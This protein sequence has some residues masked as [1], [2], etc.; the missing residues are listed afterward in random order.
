MGDGRQTVVQNVERWTT[1]R[2]LHKRVMVLPSDWSYLGNPETK[3]L[4]QRYG[5]DEAL[6]KETYVTAFTKVSEKGW[7]D[8]RLAA[9]Q[10]VE[11]TG[12]GTHITCPVAH[13]TGVGNAQNARSTARMQ[14]RRAGAGVGPFVRPSTLE[15]PVS[16]CEPSLPEAPA[17]CQLI[18]GYGLKAKLQC[19]DTLTYCLTEAASA[20]RVMIDE[21]WEK[22]G[23]EPTCPAADMAALQTKQ[24]KQAK[25]AEPAQPTRRLRSIHR[26]NSFIQSRVGIDK[27]D[28]MLGDDFEADNFEQDDGVSVEDD[29]DDDLFQNEEL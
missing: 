4:F 20:A 22:G 21:E 10:A 9:C 11:C 7:E 15:F 27:T 13:E 25:Q 16:Q 19:G 12:S 6:W 5:T 18:G 8:G 29:L 26:D 17:S 28:G 23:K 14:E 3:A 1:F 2:G 24:A